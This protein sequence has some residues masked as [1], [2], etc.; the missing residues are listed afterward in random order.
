MKLSDYMVADAVV[1]D[2]DVTTRE[3]VI[4][5]LVTALATAEKIDQ[6]SVDGIVEKIVERENMGST[7]I[8]KGIAVPHIKHSSVKNIVG[9]IG[10][11]QVGIDFKSLDQAPVYTVL[12]LV[13][14]ESDPDKHLEAMENLFSHL[15]QDSFR[16]F[17]RQ[18]H[19][20]DDIIEIINDS[21]P[22]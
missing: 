6:A 17:L 19:S 14:P 9:T 8:G 1:P 15:S 2:L 5:A 16:K 11:S 13:S 7:G 12:L 4:H 18:A 21:D 20:K 22:G 10:C 3:E